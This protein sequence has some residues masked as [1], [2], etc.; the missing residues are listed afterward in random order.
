MNMIR[1]IIKDINNKEII[2]YNYDNLITVYTSKENI[3]KMKQNKQIQYE[4]SRDSEIENLNNENTRLEN[5]ILELENKLEDQ[6]STLEEQ[7]LELEEKK[8]EIK[9][10][11]EEFNSINE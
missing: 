10:L 5:K 11:Q 7:K 4:R 8:S 3:E 9:S 2:S 1:D 6:E